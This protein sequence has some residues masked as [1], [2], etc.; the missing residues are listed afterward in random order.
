MS[1]TPILIAGYGRSGTSALMELL[2]TSPRVAFDRRY[3]F[4]NRWLTY[5]AK[6][7]RLASSASNC[8]ELGSEALCDFD[9]ARLGGIPWPIDPIAIGE[10]PIPVSDADWLTA[11]WARFSDRARERF[12]DATHYAEKAPAWLP[13]AVCDIL[14]A[15]TIHLVRDPRD[16][17]ISI[18]AFN[19]ARG[20]LA[21]G[22]KPGDSDRVYARSLAHALLVYFENQRGDAGRAE[23]VTVRFE[24]LVLDRA[25]VVARLSEFLGI[26][27]AVAQPES[28]HLTMHRTAASAEQAV[29]R[30]R[31][32][33]LPIQVRTVLESLLAEAMAGNGYE[34][35]PG[36]A[37]MPQLELA[38]VDETT[39]A[40]TGPDCWFEAPGV[41]FAARSVAEVWLCL[42][43]D[44]GNHCSLYWCR[45]NENFD[46][47]R[48]VHVPFSPGRHWQ[49]IRVSLAG[50]AHWHGAI[51]RLRLDLCN[52]DGANGCC[53]IR[54][55]RLIS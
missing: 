29:D 15:R 21:F 4:E 20:S 25:A 10:R 44:T 11:S 34:I 53:R 32:E 13:A 14:P 47:G 50:H 28:A 5:L 42:R 2:G 46:E 8:P 51:A 31:R 22:R 55:A 49:V 52:G 38:G 27:L 48:C 24:D 23:C 26:E 37:P 41:D 3:P 16:V 12:P 18:G 6:S 30:W 35:S 19:R 36:V 40:I 9:V 39:I 1:L 33:H 7:A 54:W 45:A 17:L 43:G